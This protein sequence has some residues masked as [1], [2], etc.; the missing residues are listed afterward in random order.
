MAKKTTSPVIAASAKV[1]SKA[2]PSKS[3]PVSTPVRNTPIPRV[4]VAMPA[5]MPVSHEMIARRAFEIHCSG[6]GGNQ[7]HNWLRAEAELRG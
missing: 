7:D 3:A 6:F 2:E 1:V 4:P 5:K